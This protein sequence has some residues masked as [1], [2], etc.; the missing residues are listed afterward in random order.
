MKTRWNQT[1]RESH[2][3]ASENHQLHQTQRPQKSSDWTHCEE[4][5]SL[6]SPVS[7]NLNMWVIGKTKSPAETVSFYDSVS[8][9][10]SSCTSTNRQ[11]QETHVRPESTENC[12][13]KTV[14]DRNL[15]DKLHGRNQV[16]TGAESLRTT[17]PGWKNDHEFCWYQIIQPEKPHRITVTERTL[18]NYTSSHYI[19]QHF[20]HKASTIWNWTRT[21]FS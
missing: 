16:C 14:S 6:F 1:L 15:S 19:N 18:N 4:K 17:G 11:M 10:F 20:K 7:P 9:T 21:S 12:T 8:I 5:D 3:T 2:H 13:A